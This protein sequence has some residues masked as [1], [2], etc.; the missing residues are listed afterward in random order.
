MVSCVDQ[1][2]EYVASGTRKS[3]DGYVPVP[4]S[5]CTGGAFPLG[6]QVSRL[7]SCRILRGC[8]HEVEPVTCRCVDLDDGVRSGVAVRMRRR[9]GPMC[10]FLDV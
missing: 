8:L 1:I 4:C 3:V 10:R 2:A 7:D 9:Y 6:L 5:R